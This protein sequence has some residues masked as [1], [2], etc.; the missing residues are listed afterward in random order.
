MTQKSDHIAASARRLLQTVA[1][2]ADVPLT[3]I[4]WNGER[5]EL[6]AAG[7]D[8]LEVSFTSPRALRRMLLRPT[9]QTFGELFAEGGVT[10]GD[11]HPLKIVR[12]FDYTKLN[13]LGRKI[14]KWKAFHAALPILLARDSGDTDAALAFKGSQAASAAAGR[15]DQS[16]IHFHYDLSNDFYALFLDPE[17]VYS[18]GYFDDP[19]MSLEAAQQAKLEMCCRKLKLQQGDRLFDPGCGWGALICYAAKKYGVHAHGVTLAKEQLDYCNEKI[20]RMGLQD[21]VTVEL[22]DYRS[23]DT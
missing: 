6:G 2:V 3:V 22:R 4:L 21:L 14:N 9:T 19:E 12:G 13:G 15:D 10:T 7:P 23:V 20:A 8:T 5:V 1:D 16:L 11:A 18:C 17:M